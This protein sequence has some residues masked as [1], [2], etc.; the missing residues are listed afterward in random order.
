MNKENLKQLQMLEQSLH[1]VHHQKQQFQGQLIEV[2]SAL[3]ELDKANVSYKIVGNIMIN[4]SKPELKKD[5]EE[6]KE[7]FS[8][9]LKVLDKQEQKF[10]EE[11][12]KLQQQLMKEMKE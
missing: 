2:E 8:A 11:A 6:K 3:V 7:L 12:T 10:K 5:L 9:R 4:A 1:N